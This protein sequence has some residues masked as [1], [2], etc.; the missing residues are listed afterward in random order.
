MNQRCEKSQEEVEI[1][2]TMQ[3]NEKYRERERGGEEDLERGG[4]K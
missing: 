1:E 4:K 3:E 2:K